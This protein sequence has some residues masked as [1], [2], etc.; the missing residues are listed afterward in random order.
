MADIDQSWTWPVR[1]DPAVRWTTAGGFSPDSLL[2]HPDL[3]AHRMLDRLGAQAREVHRGAPEAEE[4][5]RQSI[6]TLLAEAPWLVGSEAFTYQRDADAETHAAAEA[7]PGGPRHDPCCGAESDGNGLVDSCGVNLVLGVAARLTG[8]QGA[9]VVGALS[10]VATAAETQLLDQLGDGA[11]DH[12]A[13]ADAPGR[14]ISAR[15][16]DDGAAGTEFDGARDEFA[17]GSAAWASLSQL[18]ERINLLGRPSLEC[19]RLLGETTENI[20]DSNPPPPEPN[21]VMST[22]GITSVVTNDPCAD[23]PKVAIHGSGFGSVRPPGL[24]VIAP[25][26]D[27]TT[28]SVRYRVAKVLSWSNT[29][30]NAELPPG[31]VGGTVAFAD[32]DYIQAFNRWANI[33]NDQIIKAMRAAGC[34]G[35]GPPQRPLAWP[36]YASTP[37]PTPAAKVDLGLPLITAAVTRNLSGTAVP[38]WS[39]TALHLQAG[40][41]FWIV[42]KSANSVT[43]ALK[44]VDAVSTQVLQAAGHPA[45]GVAGREGQVRLLAPSQPS[46]LQ[47]TVEA[48]NT[49]CGKRSVPLRLVVTGAALQQG[50]TIT[51]LQSLPGG[52]VDLVNPGGAEALS[53]ATGR[54]IPLVAEKRTVV[55]IDW[56]PAVA[57]VPVGEQ[58]SAVATLRVINH[59]HPSLSGTLLPGTSTAQDPPMTSITLPSGPPFSSVEHYQQWVAQGNLPA[60]FNVVMPAD[61][62]KS[63]VTLEATV[64]ASAPKQSWTVAASRVAKFHHRRRVRIRY[65]RH[66]ADDQ[67]TPTTQ[68]AV[69]AIRAA[70]AMLPIPDPEIVVLD[71][72]PARPSSDYIADMIQERGGTPTAD[73]RNE[74]WLVVGPPGVGSV[75]NQGSQPWTGSTEAS[76]ALAAHG[77]GHMFDQRDLGLCGAAHNPEEPSSFPDEGKLVVTGWDTYSNK[78]VPNGIDVMTFCWGKSWMTPERWRRIFL[79]VGP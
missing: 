12:N 19:I 41:E 45:E 73:W 15:P 35:W 22:T 72:D 39:D 9:L 14:S 23:Q 60:T 29:L 37:T 79:K 40:Q 47:F 25:W 71:N 5:F 69:A 64:V 34:P 67:P 18:S 44:A 42:W 65:R 53:P 8:M 33:A 48:G 66:T 77:I 38:A 57:Q 6:G 70:V 46:I 50:P 10:N 31:S 16:S 1:W 74:I 59:G 32:L 4:A 2:E 51:V 78:T 49:V 21:V 24:S 36:P 61:W 75:V 52:D 68:E 7:E 55:R 13:E 54:S 63:E 26:W 56:W 76:A 20:L 11:A 28:G 43:G 62:C 30:V 27:R 58:L 3:V 17:V